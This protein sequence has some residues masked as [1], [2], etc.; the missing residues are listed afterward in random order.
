MT[1]EEHYVWRY[2]P[3]GDRLHALVNSRACAALCGLG[4]WDSWSWRGTGTQAEYERAAL[5]P[6][7]SKC[8]ARMVR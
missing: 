4:V 3:R 1:P 2:L 5:L 6:R 8:V 7:C